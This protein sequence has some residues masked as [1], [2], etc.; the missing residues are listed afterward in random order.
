MAHGEY[1][2]VESKMEQRYVLTKLHG[3]TNLLED[4]HHLR[5]QRFKGTTD[6][7]D[8][9]GI[10]LDFERIQ[11]RAHL[12]GRQLQALWYRYELDLSQTDVA[13]IMGISQQAVSKHLDNAIAKIVIIAKEEELKK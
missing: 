8:L 10:L 1:N 9:S 2:G 7:T 13:E 6:T 11:S 12:T 3:V 4:I 5:E